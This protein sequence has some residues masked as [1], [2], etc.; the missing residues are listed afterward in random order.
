[1]TTEADTLLRDLVA[2]IDR[3]AVV[4]HTAESYCKLRES[5]AYF[6]AAE[7]IGR[8][9]I[10]VEIRVADG[11]AAAVASFVTECDHGVSLDE[12]C[13][14]CRAELAPETSPDLGKRCRHNQPA[15]S[16]D[17]CYAVDG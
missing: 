2:A 8:A 13:G 3:C 6:E 7:Y 5:S 16:C 4:G 14:K 11:V 15:D 9:G 10:A 1:M 12:G 17:T